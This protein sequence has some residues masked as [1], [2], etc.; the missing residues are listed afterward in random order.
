MSSPIFM[1]KSFARFARR[2]GLA[3]AVLCEA[4]ARARGGLI[5]ADLGMGVIKQRVA[6]PG[7]GRSAGFRVIIFYQLGTSVVLVDGFAK[8]EKD[9]IGTA[10]L[11]DLRDAAATVKRFTPEAVKALVDA[12]K[13]I[14]VT[15]DDC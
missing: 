12:G 4:V 15:C 2:H 3:D 9:N 7:Q 8:S 1:I 6:R 11:K 10:D 13:W 5:D 14:K